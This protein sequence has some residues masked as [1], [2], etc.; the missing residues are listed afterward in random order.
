MARSIV[1]TSNFTLIPF[2]CQHK[3]SKTLVFAVFQGLQRHGFSDR[4]I[5]VN[6]IGLVTFKHEF[7]I[8]GQQN[9]VLPGLKQLQQCDRNF[10][11][12]QVGRQRRVSETAVREDP[13]NQASAR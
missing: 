11:I 2:H 12:P 1:N 9:T 10:L 4:P 7:R 8:S 13:E 5:Y 6:L 3:K